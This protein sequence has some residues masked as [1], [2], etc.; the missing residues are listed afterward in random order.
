MDQPVAIV[1]VGAT[2]GEGP[3]W[4]AGQGTL[5]WTDINARRLYRHMLASGTTTWQA[6]PERLGSFGLVA[7]SPKLVTAFESGFALYDPGSGDLDWFRRPEDGNTG[8]RFNDGGIDPAGRF[9]A[10]TMV[11]DDT[12]AGAESGELFCLDTNGRV[13][14]REGGIQIS[15]GLAWDP[16]A[17][18]QYFADTPRR[19]IYVYDY[20]IETGEISD[21]RVFARTPEN[22]LPDGSA[23]DRDGFL[24]NA[25][26]KGGRVVRYHPSGAV[27]GILEVPASQPT[28][29]CFAGEDLGLLV[30]TSARENLSAETL[31]SQPHAG[32]VFLYELGVR[33][34]AIPRFGLKS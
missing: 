22:A 21:R 32:D 25:Q 28:S 30:V 19:L 5:F 20:D 2:L 31:S 6:T 10:G 34:L 33:G 17:S 16:E 26:W 15:N 7:E 9:W 11:E 3:V 24:W 1:E 29:V 8:R 13:C 14:R 4:D 27:D 23:V 18:R 12:I